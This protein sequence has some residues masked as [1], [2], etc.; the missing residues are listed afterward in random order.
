MRV[1]LKN[2]KFLL[3]ILFCLKLLND[4][5][6]RSWNTQTFRFPH[7][8]FFSLPCR[9]FCIYNNPVS[10]GIKPAEGLK[11]PHIS[12]ADLPKENPQPK[13][14]PLGDSCMLTSR[15]LAAIVSKSTN[16]GVS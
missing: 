10:I 16:K 8:F 15:K 11:S 6:C 7:S 13:M 9:Q 14:L 2:E 5:M 12:I 3:E 4:L 1:F